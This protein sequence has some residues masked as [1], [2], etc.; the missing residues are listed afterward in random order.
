MTSRMDIWRAAK[1]FVDQHGHDA[2]LVAAQRAD[3]M[4]A[5][6]DVVGQAIWKR[7]TAAVEV[8]RMATAEGGQSLSSAR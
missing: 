8:L 2:P 1:L 5:R 6:G 4:L 3:E 7:I